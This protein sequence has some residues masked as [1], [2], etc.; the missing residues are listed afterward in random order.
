MSMTDVIGLI[1]GAIGALAI[2][3][4]AFRWLRGPVMIAGWQQH[5]PQWAQDMKRKEETLE[6]FKKQ[7]RQAML[8]EGYKAVYR[9]WLCREVHADREGQREYAVLMVKRK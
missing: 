3:V 8:A 1:F 7:R 9:G 4:P 5:W 2:L 6:F